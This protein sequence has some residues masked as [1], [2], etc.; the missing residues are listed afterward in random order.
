MNIKKVYVNPLTF[1][2]RILT[3]DVQN[4]LLSKEY[5]YK[6]YLLQQHFA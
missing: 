3:N 5:T 2:I 6:N 1:I 4:F